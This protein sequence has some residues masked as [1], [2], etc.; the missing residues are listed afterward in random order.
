MIN[1]YQK[2]IQQAILIRRVEQKLLDLFAQG[3]LNGT[4]HTCI[5]Q[6]FTGV[7]ISKFLN[8]ED[9]VFS[10]HRGHG[11]YLSR[12][13]DVSGLLLEVLGY[14][15]GCSGGIGGSQHFY[16][17]NYMSNGIQGGMTP[18][19][20]GVALGNELQKIDSLSVV[21]IGDGTLGQ[22]VL[23]ETLNLSS[24]WNV[25]VIFVVEKN[26][27]AQTTS[28]NQTIA[29][30][31]EYRAKAFD[32][33]YFKSTTNNVSDLM[34]QTEKAISFSRNNK[35]PVLLEIQTNRLMSH[36][37]GDDNRDP[38]KI[39]DLEKLDPINILSKENPK[40][41][42]EMK[43]IADKKINK[44][45]DEI[46]SKSILTKF[47]QK[48]E[49]KIVKNFVWNSYV[50]D[51]IRGNDAIYSSLKENMYSN[52]KI[53]LI[54]EDIE[55]SNDFNPGEYGG[56][57]KVTKDLSI[58]FK[59]RVRNTPI[60]EQAITGFATGLAIS[61]MKPVL[62]IMFGDFMTLCVDQILQHATKFR[63]MYNDKIN[64]PLIIRSPMGGYRGYGPTHSQ[65]I[66][67][68]FLGIPD[69][70]V[71]ALNHRLNPSL[72]YDQLLKNVISPTLVI[73]NK[74]AYTRKMNI[75]FP[76]YLNISISNE[77]YP[78][79]KIDFGENSKVE[80][81]ILCYGGALIPVEDAIKELFF[82]EEITGVVIC[83]SNISD[84]NIDILSPYV[85]KSK[86]LIIVE[87][88]NSFAALGSEIVT[89]LI[90][91]G[92]NIGKVKRISN[93]TIIPSSSVAESNLL[94]NKKN[95]YQKVLEIIS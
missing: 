61:G 64:I 68:L 3:R 70:S 79:I 91:K 60:S 46:E 76:D 85:E 26:G 58:L 33:E 92:V 86:N 69:L 25:P 28:N 7:A 81:T 80:Y 55:T 40:L 31:I 57:F 65:S 75:D 59:D 94:P 88:G 37:K 90:E 51:N 18:I 52:D 39:K 8:A 78:S 12:T 49:F 41:F 17:K 50:L 83:P 5:G 22:G 63:L 95:I 27:I 62:E 66:E 11:H 13:N 74:I 84:V 4:V 35:R 14:K 42:S 30:T 48:S 6:E 9:F 89:Q 2:E 16:N 32:I 93:N 10:N 56:A 36:S 24:V 23:Y 73:E 77:I 47:E 1:K 29:G 72:I 54:G 15:D 19:A 34:D 45:M 38:L 67:K 71:L 87:E 43:L 44:I 21:Y 82:E 20:S 53:I